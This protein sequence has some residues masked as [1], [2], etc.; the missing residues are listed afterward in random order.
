MISGKPEISGSSCPVWAQNWL[1]K[2]TCL[3]IYKDYLIW[4]VFEFV[5][6]KSG[7]CFEPQETLISVA[8]IFFSQYSCQMCGKMSFK[9]WLSIIIRYGNNT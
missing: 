8:A 9:E 1:E 4:E 3:V 5:E 7:L 2:L 6:F